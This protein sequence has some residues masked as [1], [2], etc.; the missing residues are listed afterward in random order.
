[1]FSKQSVTLKISAVLVLWVEWCP[2]QI[3]MLK[4]QPLEP[5]N[6]TVFENRVI[7]DMTDKD[8]AIL[9]QG[10]LLSNKTGILLKGGIWTQTNT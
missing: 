8:E 6:V 7:A 2:P 1:M 9:K 3:I 5:Q 10:G 4:Y